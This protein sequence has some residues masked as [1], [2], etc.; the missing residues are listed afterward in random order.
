MIHPNGFAADP[1]FQIGGQS[2]IDTSELFY[3]GNSQGGIQGG[4]LAAFAQDWTRAVLG[5]PG[6]NFSTLLNR[7]RDF[8]DFN[9]FF[10][11]AYSEQPRSPVAALGDRNALGAG[12]GER[13]RD[14]SHVGSV[15]EHA[16]EEDPDARGAGRLPGRADH[17]RERG[18]HDRRQ[19]AH[20]G[21]RFRRSSSRTSMPFFGIEPIESYPYDGSA[22]I[23]VGQRQPVADRRRRPA[24]HRSAESRS[25]CCSGRARRAAAAIRTSVRAAR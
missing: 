14:A 2:L 24:G 19:P 13:T 4:G 3:D 20:A 16:A 18:A 25:G 1:A 7:S 17:R 11:A 10:Q 23:Y 6:M 21:D 22:I 15:S 9:L 5:V 8:D 12:G